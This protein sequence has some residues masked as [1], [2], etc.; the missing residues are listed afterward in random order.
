MYRNEE[1]F[2]KDPSQLYETQARDVDCLVAHLWD[3]FPDLP[4]RPRVFEPACGLGAIVRALKRHD[5][6]CTVVRDKY[7][8]P[9]PHGQTHDFLTA[10][11]PPEC[12]Y[13]LIVCNPPFAGK[14][15]W[16]RRLEQTGKPF[17]V[18]LP[19]DLLG[20]LRTQPP[21]PDRVVTALITPWNPVFTRNGCK[22]EIG[23]QVAW[24]CSRL[25]TEE[26]R[27]NTKAGPRSPSLYPPIHLAPRVQYS[28]FQPPPQHNPKTRQNK[29]DQEAVSH[30]PT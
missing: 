4:E 21:A 11:F 29:Q 18:L 30:R 6:E 22:A 24:L 23:C 25:M 20:R 3:I 28:S 17:A 16:W 15:Q 7:L 9:A 5:I 26:E 2:K 13:D 12:S 27:G 19:F 1:R 8:A 10:A 14:K